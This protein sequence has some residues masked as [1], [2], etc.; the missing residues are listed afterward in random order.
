VFFFKK[1]C[2]MPVDPHFPD[3]I[4]SIS[5]SDSDSTLTISDDFDLSSLDSFDTSPRSGGHKYFDFQDRPKVMDSKDD[6]PVT[7]LKSKSKESKGAIFHIAGTGVTADSAS[8][9]L[10]GELHYDANQNLLPHRYI[11]GIGARK[12]HKKVWRIRLDALRVQF[13]FVKGYSLKKHKSTQAS[14]YEFLKLNKGENLSVSGH[15]RGAALGQTGL[16]KRLYWDVKKLEDLEKKTEKLFREFAQITRSSSKSL[17]KKRKSLEQQI[18][19]NKLKIKELSSKLEQLK[20]FKKITFTFIDPVKGL[21]LNN[22]GKSFLFNL[23]QRFKNGFK[24]PNISE[25]DMLSHIDDYLHRGNSSKDS[26]RLFEVFIVSSRFEGRYFYNLDEQFKRVNKD[27]DTRNIGEIKHSSSGRNSRT[28]ENESALRSVTYKGQRVTMIAT[29]FH[30]NH[31]V[32]D[33]L[34]RL[35][36]AKKSKNKLLLKLKGQYEQSKALYRSGTEANLQRTFPIDV[37]RAVIQYASGSIS[38]REL[39]KVIDTNENI[40][41]KV[42]QEINHCIR[43][44]Y[45]ID[46]LLKETIQLAIKNI[47]RSIL[48]TLEFYKNEGLELEKLSIDRIVSTEI[49]EA[50][51]IALNKHSISKKL[52]LEAVAQSKHN[53][54]SDQI[55]TIVSKLNSGITDQ[56]IIL[57]FPNE[58]HHLSEDQVNAIIKHSQSKEGITKQQFLEIVTGVKNIKDVLSE[59][60]DKKD[61]KNVIKD[62]AL[63]VV[64]DPQHRKRYISIKIKLKSLL[65]KSLQKQLELTSKRDLLQQQFIEKGG[66]SE[67]YQEISKEIYELENEL[68]CINDSIKEVKKEKE[69]T[70]EAIREQYKAVTREAN[71]K[72]SIQKLSKEVSRVGNSYEHYAKG[73]IKTLPL[74]IGADDKFYETL[75]DRELSRSIGAYKKYKK[76]QDRP[77]FRSALVSP[78][79]KNREKKDIHYLMNRLSNIP[80]RKLRF[81]SILRSFTRLF[82][83]PSAIEGQESQPDMDAHQN[84]TRLSKVT[85]FQSNSADSSVLSRGRS[86]KIATSIPNRANSLSSGTSSVRSNLSNGS[87]R[88]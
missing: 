56:Q 20:N 80:R 42:I 22:T 45:S 75:R 17:Q 9:D 36:T 72:K 53:F 14:F 24:N 64:K 88:S 58:K 47:S 3:D 6:K 49:E 18:K 4:V 29:G 7:R 46:H 77:F 16:I 66:D 81:T 13:R 5:D 50:I 19:R 67:T 41:R 25:L 55:D 23:K 35:N 11:N 10:G 32:Q 59:L 76:D 83:K 12:A 27:Q 82:Y 62:A 79:F 74:L 87:R 68:K 48:N 30:H 1:I 71:D 54:I 57:L 28:Q 65:E 84:L 70:K 15:S 8:R 44:K 31:M 2:F 61:V 69:S 73:L 38:E 60:F 85:I 52:I 51:N 86:R 39:S 21:P 26:K 43:V 40:E 78:K 63:K 34:N 37:V 33:P